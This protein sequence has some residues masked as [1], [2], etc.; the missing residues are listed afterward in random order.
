MSSFVRRPIYFF[1]LAAT[2]ATRAHAVPV[3]MI[4]IDGLKPQYITQAD[5]HGLMLSFLRTLVRNGSYA[6]GVVGVWPTVTYPSHTTHITGVWP[7]AHGIE[8]NLQFDPEKKFGGAWYWYA[9]AIKAPT[10]WKAAHTAGLRTASIGWPVSVGATD[11]DFLIPEYWRSS[12][13]SVSFDSAGRMLLDVL[14]RPDALIRQLVP[15]VGTYMQGNETTVEGDEVKTRYAIEIL[16]REKPAFMT[17]HLSSLDEAEHM[18]APFSIEAGNTLEALDGMVARLDAA[19]RANDPSTVLVL[20]SDHG[21]MKVT[22]QVHLFIPFLQA[23]L[24]TTTSNSSSTFSSIQSWKAE[25]V[26]EEAWLR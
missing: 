6:D 3:L 22:H 12:G 1:L 4:S 21:F 9:A 15:A 16:R 7:A 20:V 8:N 2:L 19:A 5:A 13:P 10:L 17:L 23:G 14:S 18:D 26:S 11:V 24:I 25:H